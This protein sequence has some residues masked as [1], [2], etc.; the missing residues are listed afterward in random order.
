MSSLG[1]EE[2]I[3]CSCTLWNCRPTLCRA[4]VYVPKFKTIRTYPAWII[5]G[6][7]IN[8]PH[9]RKPLECKPDVCAAFG[10][11]LQIQ[12]TARLVGAGSK[13]AGCSRDFNLRFLKKCLYREPTSCSP[14]AP[15]AVTHAN[16]KRIAMCRILHR[17]ANASA[18]VNIG[19]SKLP[20]LLVGNLNENSG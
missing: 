10:A 8:H 14:L 16:P 19:H 3:E 13:L 17:A 12:P 5:K 7:T 6:A 18:F 20:K 1:R 4:K 9:V 2:R 11:E 15:R